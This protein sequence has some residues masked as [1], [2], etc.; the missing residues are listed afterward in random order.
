MGISPRSL[1]KFLPGKAV[2]WQIKPNG[3]PMKTAIIVVL[4]A[5][6][7]LFWARTR[8]RCSNRVAIKEIDA[9]F[10][11]K[12]SMKKMGSNT[13]MTNSKRTV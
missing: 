4:T 13:M 6:I 9:D 3:T 5:R 1:N 12:T 7:K 8:W 11:G 10:R 2:R